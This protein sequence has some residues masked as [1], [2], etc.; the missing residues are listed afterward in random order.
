[1]TT[2]SIGRRVRAITGRLVLAAATLGATTSVVAAAPAGAAATDPCKVITRAEIQR[3]FGGT[4]STGRL[5]F[6]TRS[7]SQCQ[8][9]VGAEGNRPAGTVVVHLMNTGAKAAY[10]RYQKASGYAPIDGVPNALWSET[11]HR[12]NVLAGDVLLA[13]QGGFIATTPLPIHS[14]DDKTQLSQ[15]AQIGITRV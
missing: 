6:T 12:V 2:R 10:E 4:V 14:Y 15:L 7:S 3:A 5:G 11:L 9:Q 13:V 8:F 1:M